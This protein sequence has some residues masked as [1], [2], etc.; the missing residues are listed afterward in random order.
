MSVFGVYA[1]YYDL[2][3]RD[4]DYCQEA[5]FVH[6][7]VERFAPEGKTILELGCGTGGHAEHLVR[8]GFDIHGVDISDDMLKIAEERRMKLAP[9]LC[10]RLK[11]SRGDVR[12]IRLDR[13]F[14]VVISLFHVMSYQ[15]TNQDLLDAFATARKHLKSG[16]IFVFDCWYGPAVLSDPPTVRV[17]R[18]ADDEM[19]VLRI[20]EPVVHPNDNVVDVNYQILVKEV[21]DN[22]TT[23]ISE[24]HRMRYLFKPEVEMMLAAVG[25]SLEESVEF[26]NNRVPGLN[27]WSVCFVARV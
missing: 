5:D 27:S 12:S 25:F 6:A 10:S 17:K 24:T 26:L 20:A 19:Q 21:S 13:E 2:I 8:S 23:E 11:L 14:D 18:W 22:K 16:G 7:L 4:K 9:D 3:Y 1:R 15:T